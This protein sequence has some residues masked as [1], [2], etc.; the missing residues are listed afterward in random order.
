MLPATFNEH[1]GVT[2]R[3]HVTGARWPHVCRRDG[4]CHGGKMFPGAQKKHPTG[5]ISRPGNH[6]AGDHG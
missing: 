1:E 3:E 5:P 4:H 6:R 2:I